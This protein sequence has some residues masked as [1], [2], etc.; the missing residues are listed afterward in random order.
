MWKIISIADLTSCVQPTQLFLFAYG[1]VLS[2]LFCVYIFFVLMI[3]VI[4]VM[5]LL[6]LIPF[7]FPGYYIT[8]LMMS[9]LPYL[10]GIVGVFLLI[11]F[12]QLKRRWSLDILTWHNVIFE[13]F[14]FWCSVDCFFSGVSNSI[15]FILQKHLLANKQPDHWRCFLPISTRTIQ[16]MRR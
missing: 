4:F 7:F 10:V 14:R 12:V 3:A 8:E 2:M 9:F 16:T 13:G 15:I 6:L 5:V 11:S 1:F